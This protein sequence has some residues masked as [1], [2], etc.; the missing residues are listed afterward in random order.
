MRSSWRPDGSYRSPAPPSPKVRRVT[1][2]SANK[3]QSQTSLEKA[4][5]I[6][7]IVFI[8]GNIAVFSIW[9][10]NPD[11]H[12]HS[13]SLSHAMA[14]PHMH[15]R[16]DLLASRGSP[17]PG[18]AELQSL[19]LQPHNDTRDAMLPPDASPHDAPLAASEGG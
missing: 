19:P 15:S 14:L 18:A 10:A 3:S 12:L 1:T 17:P 6:F 5:L 16:R 13:H 11:I 7:G 2:P 9:M 4:T 8:V